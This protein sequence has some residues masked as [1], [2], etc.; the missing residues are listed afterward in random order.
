MRKLLITG[1]AGF[2][3]QHFVRMKDVLRIEFGWNL[4]VA[5]QPYDLK[6]TADLASLVS[7]ASPHGVIHL[8]GISFIP[9]SFK[10]P[11]STFVINTLGTLNLLQALKKQGFAGRFL[12]ISS[13]DVYGRLYQEDLP[14]K[15]TQTL[16]P[17]N[18]YAVSKVAAEAL[19]YQWSQAKA[20]EKVVIARPFNH[21]GAGQRDDFVISSLAKQ[22][23]KIRKG[24]Q[25][26]IIRAGDIDVTRD[27]LDVADVIRAYLFLLDYG[28]NG[29]IYN[30]CGGKERTIRETITTLL[31]EAG[32]DANILPESEC[33][34]PTEQRRSVGDNQKL[35][36]ATSWQ[37]SI[38]FVTTL[39]NVLNYWELQEQ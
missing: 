27:F 5:N 38:P 21:I 10:D 1:E 24:L 35:I 12:Y 3:G 34:R 29:E 23:V 6:D 31:I 20:F 14:V 36:E 39:N 26:P 33:F 11:E 17:L 4:V 19:C 13:G 32:I 30:V 2:V 9:D 7:D 25:P 15:E 18:P 22:I 28:V 16:R 37:P 8:A